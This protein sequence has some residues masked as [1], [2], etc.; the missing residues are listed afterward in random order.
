M[1]MASHV[2]KVDVI[3]AKDFGEALMYTS[4]EFNT[5]LQEATSSITR[6]TQATSLDGLTGPLGIVQV[7]ADLAKVDPLALIKFSAFISINLAVVNALP[8]PGLGECT[9]SIPAH[10]NYHQ[11]SWVSQ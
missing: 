11:G 4:Q 1:K 2:E 10:G 8:V 9:E 3:K 6:I 5:M 7:G